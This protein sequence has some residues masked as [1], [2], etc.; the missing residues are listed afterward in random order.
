MARVK[1]QKGEI[2][3]LSLKEAAALRIEDLMN[4]TEASEYLKET[5][6]VHI[7]ARSLDVYRSQGRGP[8]YLVDAKSKAVRYVAADLDVYATRVSAKV[9]ERVFEV[10]E[11][12]RVNPD[13]G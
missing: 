6:D 11:A 12:I 10:E 5:H 8:S 13:K 2:E 7:G 3:E 9:G 4:S 1:K